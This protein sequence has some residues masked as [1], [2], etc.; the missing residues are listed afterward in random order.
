MARKKDNEKQKFYALKYG[1]ID[2]KKRIERSYEKLRKYFNP[3]VRRPVH[4]SFNSYM[5]AYCWLYDKPLPAK[6]RPPEAPPLF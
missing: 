5:E 1:S 4:K 6:K 2:G 3:D